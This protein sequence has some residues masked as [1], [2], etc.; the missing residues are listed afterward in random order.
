MVGKSGVKSKKW[1]YKE[2]RAGN[3]QTI[4]IMRALRKLQSKDVIDKVCYE[5]IETLIEYRDNAV[6][7]YNDDALLAQKLQ[8]VGTA[9][10]KSYLTLIQEWFSISLSKYNFWLMPLS[11]FHPEKLNSVILGKRDAAV[12]NLLNY[13]ANKEAQ[14][15][16][17]PSSP[18]NI[19]VTIE[20]RIVKA[21]ALDAQSIRISSDSNAPE[22]QISLE[23][24][25]KTHPL[26]YDE[27]TTKLRYRYKNFKVNPKYHEL[28][29]ILEKDPKYC[30]HYPQNPK[31][32]AGATKPLFSPRVFEE[33][34]KN[35]KLRPKN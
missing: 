27:L 25:Q 4:D 28:R 17:T 35:Y 24:I 6:H 12:A 33:F 19:T 29:R 30:F 9:T 7:F 16:S 10:I 8:E 20:T 21:G 18:H 1:K 31:K 23:D 32:P 3:K 22:Y 5:N 34:D 13:I 14:Y 26:D 2:N 11:F 15:P